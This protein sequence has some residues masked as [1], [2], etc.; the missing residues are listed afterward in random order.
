M[1][2]IAEQSTLASDSDGRREAIAVTSRTRR[3]VVVATILFCLLPAIQ[4]GLTYWISIQGLAFVLVLYAVN[5][6]LSLEDMAICAL[7]AA[8]MLTGLVFQPDM[9]RPTWVFMHNAFE[10]LGIFVIISAAK[11]PRWSMPDR[12]LKPILVAAVLGVF[13]LTLAQ[14]VSY[15]FLKE[16][17]FLLPSSL[18]ATGQATNASDRLAWSRLHGFLAEV[19]I[20]ATFAEPSYLGFI[21]MCLTVLVLNSRRHSV[22]TLGLLAALLATAALSKSASSVMMIS[23]LVTYAYRSRLNLWTAFGVAGIG[24]VLLAVAATAL[25]FDPIGRLLRSA[26]PRLEPS[27]YIRLIM[28]LQHVATVL[29]EAPFGVAWSDVPTFFAH[30]ASTYAMM[31]PVDSTTGELNGQDNGFLNLFIQFGWTAFIVIVGVIVSIRDRFILLFLLLVAQF[32]GA[33]LSPDKIA[34]I[35]L[36]LVC[37]PTHRDNRAP[38]K[39]T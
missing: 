28:P 31:N 5:K 14:Y 37:K 36:A 27:G 32:N 7:I 13:T 30:H 19:R 9:G 3:G 1:S 12:L 34:M 39:A 23:L 6:R 17:R 16:P 2:D 38:Q 29:T 25:D 21:L 20:S 35:S 4:L 11:D 18:Y 33:P 8:A 10:A 26:D 22:A 15:T 24:A